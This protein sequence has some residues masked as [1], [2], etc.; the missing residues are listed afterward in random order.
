MD[1]TEDLLTRLKRDLALQNK[2]HQDHV[3]QAQSVVTLTA[4]KVKSLADQER[5][6]SLRRFRKAV[7][8]TKALPLLELT[9][10]TL[11]CQLFEQLCMN[12]DVN[13]E[14]TSILPQWSDVANQLQIDDLRIQ[15]VQTC[16]RPKEGLTR[17][18][19]EMYMRD[20]GTL[21]Q[22]LGAL[23]DLELF[24][25]LGRVVDAVERFV[26]DH[27][28]RPETLKRPNPQYFSILATLASVFGPQDPCSDIYKLSSL[29]HQ[30]P[31]THSV[32]V[33]SSGEGRDNMDFLDQFGPYK[34]EIH[35]KLDFD[36]PA[37]SNQAQ[38][39][40]LCRILL[41]FASDGV[42][43]SEAIKSWIHGFEFENV[44]AEVFQLN[45][46]SMWFE[47]MQNP[48]ACCLK[49]ANEADY[50]VP[51]LTPN[52]LREIHNGSGPD[53]EG[54]LP[55]SATLNRFL[56]N[57]LRARYAQEGCKNKVVR[58]II[59]SEYLAQISRCQAVQID[60]VLRSVWIPMD[61]T[62]V[63]GRLKSMLNS[64]KMIVSN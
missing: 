20:N 64:K 54:L 42:E 32:L 46:V 44:R 2:V 17:A 14:Y 35:S 4:E 37:L 58:P 56:Y 51:I 8:R 38:D 15:W 22:V 40:K 9:Y 7:E 1:G 49:W 5:E 13:Q 18:I 26:K 29:N 47:V 53:G 63:E 11:G 57:C 55:T 19:L 23:L 60:P 62:R 52:Y 27:E 43:F 36:A 39:S 31:L 41:L 16:V 50:V 61:R 34:P 21:G 28:S 3:S 48:E 59:P 6:A 30:P 25:V 45:E 10:T 33:Q 24:A 12:I